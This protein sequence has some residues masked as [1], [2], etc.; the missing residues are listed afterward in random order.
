MWVSVK[1]IIFQLN[2]LIT[3]IQSDQIRRI[4]NKVDEPI[5]INI[6]NTNADYGQS[7]GKLNGQF[8]DSQLLIDSLLRMKSNLTDKNDLMALCQREYYNNDTQLA[9]VRE[10]EQNY[11]SDRSLWWYTRETFLYRLLNKALREQNID[12]LFLFRFFIRD[13]ERELNQYRCSSSLLLYRAQLMS[14]K[15]LQ[16][17]QDSIGQ[18]ISMNSFLST[19]INRSLATFYLGESIVNDDLQRVLFEIDADCT[20]EGVKPFANI[21]LLSNFPQEEEEVLMM[22]GSIFRLNN[23]S[24]DETQ[25]W[26]IRM[27]L[28]SDNDHDL[29]TIFDHMKNQL[30]GGGETNLPSFGHVLRDMGKF[31][32]ANKYYHRLLN[33]LPNDHADIEICYHALGRVAHEKGDYDSSLEW[34]EK[35]LAIMQQTL[36][37]NHPDI[38]KA[39]NSIGNAHRKKL[40]FQRA[41]ESYGNA[42]MIVKQAFGEDH[43]K[44]AYGLGNMGLVYHL[45]KKHSEALDCH[46]KGVTILEKHLPADHPD[47]GKSHN[48]IGEAYYSLG[49][50]DLALKHYRLALEIFQK[51]LPPQHPSTTHVLNNIDYFQ[52][53]L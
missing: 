34:H 17:L 21:S 22:L 11:T 33:E 42:L 20:K 12:L 39:Y 47:L 50:Y 44:V 2:D 51:S 6:F 53:F 14:N 27:T 29:K 35:S 10:F 38:A 16:V 26:I 3:Q 41:L 28:R 18:L 37:S 15:E 8:V 30:A 43:T 49:Y 31:D 19:S 23:I 46:Q 13:I 32:D 9:I 4:Q 7:T 48:N 52:K 36:K 5:S 40:D 1:G 24:Y 45:E 25:G